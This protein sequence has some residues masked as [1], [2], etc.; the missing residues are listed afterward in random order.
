MSFTMTKLKVQKKLSAFFFDPDADRPKSSQKNLGVETVAGYLAGAPGTVVVEVSPDDE[1]KTLLGQLATASHRRIAYTKE[2]LI[3]VSQE[4]PATPEPT[5][6]VQDQPE[7]EEEVSAPSV[8]A[9]PPRKAK[10]ER[11]YQTLTTNFFKGSLK[12]QI[13]SV[14]KTRESKPEKVA[15]FK[16]AIEAGVI[17]LDREELSPS[18]MKKLNE[19]GIEALN[20]SGSPNN[21][22]GRTSSSENGGVEW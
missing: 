16:A 20:M 19:L 4:G 12:G 22:C 14:W 9:L 8:E 15:D 17:Q 11:T 3:L 1:A 5:T 13:N 2:G 21:V 6:E 10:V 18:F 7:I